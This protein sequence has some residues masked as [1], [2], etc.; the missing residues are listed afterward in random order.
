[1]E[2]MDRCEICEEPLEAGG[3]LVGCDQCGRLYGPCCNPMEDDVC[4]ECT[5]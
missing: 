5:E 2:E 4:V 3:C 1:M